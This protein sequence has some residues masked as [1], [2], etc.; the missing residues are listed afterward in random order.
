MPARNHS[1]SS[2]LGATL[3]TLGFSALAGVLVT[4]MVAPALAVTGM[5]AS[6]T[7]GIFESLPDFIEL[8]TQRQQNEIY[9]TDAAGTPIR[10]ATIYDQNRQEIPLAEMSPFLQE[11][12]IAGEDR[13]FW[14][15]G[16]VDVQSVVRAAI[17]SATS[18]E[19][20]GGASTLTMQTVRNILVLNAENNDDLTPEQKQAAKEEATDPNFGRKLKEMKL[21]ISLEKQYSKEEILQGYLNIANFGR[22]TYGVQAAALQYFSVNAIDLTLP[23]A[24]SII[25]IVQNPSKLSLDNPEHYAANQARRDLIMRDMFEVG[26]IT[27]EELDAAIAIPVDP[28]FLRLS[29]PRNGCRWADPRF[30]L[31]CDYIRKSIPELNSLGSTPE[32]RVANF[33]TGGYK[34]YGTLDPDLQTVAREQ[35][36][37]Y[38]PPTEER[39][40]L[41]AAVS[42]V[43]PGSGR[44]LTMAQNKEFDDSPEAAADP[45]K[46]AVNMTADVT[47]GGSKGFQPGSTYKMFTLLS[48]LDAGNGIN[49]SFNAGLLTINQSKFKDSCADESSAGRPH[50]GNYTFKNDDNEKGSYTVSRGTSQS[51]NSVFLQ[52]ATKVDQCST[53]NIAQSLGV[54]RAQDG[55]DSKLDTIPSCVIGGCTNNVDPL[56]MAGA[57]AAIA[58]QGVYCKPIAVDR[59]VGPDDVELPGQDAGCA[60]TLTPSVANTAAFAASGVMSGTAAASN[61]RD[62]TPYFGKTGTTDESVHTWMVGSSTAASTAVWVGNIQGTQAM[63]KIRV[64]GLQASV[65][66]HSIFRPLAQA[67]DAKYPGAEF[68]KADPALLSGKPTI[69]PDVSGQTPQAAAPIIENAD[70][71]FADGGPIDS[72]R[73]AGT[74]VRSDPPGGTSVSKGTTI[75]VFT[76]N[77]NGVSVP[78]V[79]GQ[80]FDDAKRALQGQGFGAIIPG[81]CTAGGLPTDPQNVVTGQIPS[82]GTVVGR[83][84]DIVLDVQR[85]SC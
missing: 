57:Y 83:G 42:T 46:T 24:A 36:Q 10:I 80:N 60:Q 16:G 64:G 47:R 9:L 55:P 35:V 26:Y 3:G 74:I 73:P 79:S 7:I 38:A 5:T 22:N 1:A 61:P 18:S 54:F 25:A 15:H 8:G 21:A 52:M 13:R 62:G 77:G 30:S 27:Q 63:R 71:A 78:D 66:R 81:E 33:K 41:G 39:F 67:I 6:S 34:I 49:Q 2:V 53:R 20:T 45:V 37:K 72:D 44:I 50:G 56:M 68:Q 31:F 70:L 76:S 58:A 23:Q 14:E 69:V 32:E 85:F 4:V 29:E 28:N 12:A 40:A 65:L 19:G 84:Q 43:Q 75:T 11:G 48:Y 51:V 17:G 82:A 59:V